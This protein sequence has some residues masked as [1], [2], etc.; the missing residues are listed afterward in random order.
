MFHR[1]QSRFQFD[2][3]SHMCRFLYDLLHKTEQSISPLLRSGVQT[4]LAAQTLVEGKQK[5]ALLS[6]SQ[7][8]ANLIHHLTAALPSLMTS[9]VPPAATD[10]ANATEKDA[11]DA[12]E[13]LQLQISAPNPST[14]R[15]ETLVR[16]FLDSGDNA[17]Q[18]VRLKF[19]NALSGCLSLPTALSPSMLHEVEQTLVLRFWDPVPA[20]RAAAIRSMV[21]FTA[22]WGE[23]EHGGAD[24]EGLARSL[25]A[26]LDVLDKLIL[27]LMDSV[28]D[29][30]EEVCMP[31]SR[32]EHVCV[33]AVI[34]IN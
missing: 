20:V 13:L 2:L 4:R 16:Q 33:G 1:L 24:A 14:K 25:D 15:H 11:L 9:L 8:V 29:V 31:T 6:S 3:V 12:F 28:P 19:V 27:R 22:A 10:M 34:Q 23:D 21:S 17:S 5:S 26:H 18:R 32:H 7:L 30:R